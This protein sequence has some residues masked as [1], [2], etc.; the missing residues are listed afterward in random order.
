MS[1]GPESN[2][3]LHGKV[4]YGAQRAHCASRLKYI[5]R[6]KTHA[7][8]LR[9]CG[10]NSLDSQRFT[11]LTDPFVILLDVC[12]L[13]V[14]AASR[15]KGNRPI[16]HPEN[17]VSASGFNVYL[18][19]SGRSENRGVTVRGPSLTQG[20]KEHREDG[21][22]AEGKSVRRRVKCPSFRTRKGIIR[23][24]LTAGSPRML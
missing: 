3:L 7:Y 10:M 13:N 15:P 1:S 11:D 14:R 4:S 23:P 18:I 5:L 20:E 2:R 17:Y 6:F 16:S 8:E 24:R 12:V 19:P 21:S 22:S 9:S